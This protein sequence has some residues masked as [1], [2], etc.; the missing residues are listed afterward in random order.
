MQFNT[1]VTMQFNRGAMQFNRGA[2]ILRQN[3]VF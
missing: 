3:P 1:L 2:N